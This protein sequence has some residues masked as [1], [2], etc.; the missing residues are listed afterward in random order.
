MEDRHCFS[1]K[2][3]LVLGISITIRFIVDI[4]GK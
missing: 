4:E 2:G 1:F 3:E